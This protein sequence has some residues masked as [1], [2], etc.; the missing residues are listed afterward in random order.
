MKKMKYIL[1]AALTL[2]VA[3]SCTKQYAEDVQVSEGVDVKAVFE[4]V[5]E[6]EVS[7]ALLQSD[8]SLQW[9]EGDQIGVYQYKNYATGANRDN[10][11]NI[12]TSDGTCKFEGT[13]ANYMPL[14]EGG[15]QNRYYAVYPAANCKANGITTG[16][17]TIE[18]PSVQT[19]LLSDFKK[20]TV[21][22][23]TIRE[24]D[25]TVSYDAE[26]K[27]LTF[28]KSFNMFC[29]T[30]VL[31]INVPAAL[32]VTKIELSALNADGDEIN[33]AGRFSDVRSDAGT[34][35]V[36]VTNQVATTITVENGGDVLSG[37]VYVVLAPNANAGSDPHALFKSTAKTLMLNLSAVTEAGTAAAATLK[38][39]LTGEVLA[40]T[41]KNLPALPSNVKWNL[42]TGPGISKI[43]INKTA[44]VTET[45]TLSDRTRILITPEDPESV[46]KYRSR[47]NLAEVEATTPTNICGETGILRQAAETP[48]NYLKL[49]VSK[50]GY[51]DYSAYACTWI[52]YKGYGFGKDFDA[53]AST[54]N[55]EVGSRYPSEG[56]KYNLS[57]EYL[58]LGTASKIPHISSDGFYL[59]PSN[60]NSKFCF[61]NLHIQSPGTGRAKLFF[62]YGVTSN[63]R[64][65][66]VKR[67]ETQI[68]S[69]STGKKETYGSTRVINTDFFDVQ[70]GDDLTVSLSKDVIFYSITLLWEPE[71]T[72]ANLSTES[73]SAKTSYGK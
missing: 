4:A 43:E 47:A 57:F 13:I 11:K 62:D 59:I 56:Y 48:E 67:G 58:T 37:D 22:L 14:G 3:A 54:L 34:Q 45:A 63:A 24:S 23:G 5:V 55:P 32:G 21:Y 38:L 19:G 42:P 46:I 18:V 69:I 20:N 49:S 65:L 61:G 6:D 66:T 10:S 71:E 60:S 52:L 27:T 36:A 35:P 40:G 64:T 33:I 15:T 72:K 2:F 50:E 8:G 28:F 29:M 53:D 16:K 26:A 17:Y 7:K 73:Y 39:P 68:A 12:F 25:E 70:A 1:S 9:E 44:I 31:K 41:I 51:A 30:P